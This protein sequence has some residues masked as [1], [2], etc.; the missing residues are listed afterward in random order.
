MTT[1][2]RR[3]PVAP[4]GPIRR[5]PLPKP[6]PARRRYLE[7]VNALARG[8]AEEK[9]DGRAARR[10]REDVLRDALDLFRSGL[11]PRRAAGV[12]GVHED[13]ARRLRRDLVAAGAVLPPLREDI[14]RDE[15]QLVLSAVEG[16][17]LSYDQAA[18]ELGWTKSKVARVIRRARQ[19]RAEATG[20]GTP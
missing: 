18:T 17:G 4:M 9:A 5:R 2:T 19:R 1:S 16:D 11:S 14:E 7:Q 10:P 12:L 6:D 8:I 3:V 15:D 13:T 20:A